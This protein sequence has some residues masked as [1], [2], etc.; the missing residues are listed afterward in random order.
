[1]SDNMRTFEESFAPRG[2]VMVKKHWWRCFST[3]HACT[4]CPEFP[5]KSQNAPFLLEGARVS[6]FKWQMHSANF[7]KLLSWFT[8]HII[9]QM[10]RA[11]E[12]ASASSS[13]FPFKKG[14][15]GDW[16]LQSLLEAK[17][18]DGHFLH[19]I[20]F[21]SR[22]SLWGRY[23]SHLNFTGEKTEDQRSDMISTR[24]Y[25]PTWPTS[26]GPKGRPRSP[27]WLS[28]FPRHPPLNSHEGAR[29]SQSPQPSPCKLRN[30][31]CMSASHSG[32]S[33]LLSGAGL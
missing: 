1:M 22:N 4:E 15:E 3:A 21:Q 5:P 29:S 20:L 32:S 24:P 13:V 26:K 7:R 10:P 8:G 27:C 30:S 6:Q 17:S 11:L 16:L 25:S 9:P 31:S 12:M 14:E 33:L 2:H 19:F 18:E 23:Y 28:S